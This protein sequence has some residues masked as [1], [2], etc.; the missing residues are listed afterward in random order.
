[1]GGFVTQAG[2]HPIVANTQ[3]RQYLK[4]IADIKEEDIVDKSKVDILIT[5]AALGQVVW[6]AAQEAARLHE[7]LPI[8]TLETATVAFAGVQMATWMLW[9]QKP[10]DVSEPIL[11]DPV[12]PSSTALTVGSEVESYSNRDAGRMPSYTI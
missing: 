9:R 8:S 3:L 5:C 2:H 10:R 11:L 7:G 12:S 6:F 4:G 1:M